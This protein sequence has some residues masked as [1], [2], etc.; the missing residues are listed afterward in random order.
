MLL[1]DIKYQPLLLE[2]LIY[3]ISLQQ[4]ALKGMPLNKR[5]K[6]LTSGSIAA[7]YIEL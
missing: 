1:V 6:E 5:R 4:T 3:Q 7:P 2:E